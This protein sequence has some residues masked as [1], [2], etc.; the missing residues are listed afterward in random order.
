[1][2]PVPAAVFP[3][4]AA[5]FPIPDGVFPALDVELTENACRSANGDHGA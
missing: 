1:M 3:I 2:S 5:V 4:P